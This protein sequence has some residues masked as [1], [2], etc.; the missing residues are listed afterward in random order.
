MAV[1][2]RKSMM[3]ALLLWLPAAGWAQSTPEFP[4]L[5]G[6]V[7]DRAEMLSPDV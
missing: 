2:S 6:R 7:V 4:E 5:T 1:L 3:L